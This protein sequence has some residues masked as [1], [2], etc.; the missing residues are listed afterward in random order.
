L[1]RRIIAFYTGRTRSASALLRRQ[2]EAIVADA[3]VRATLRRMVELAYILR[4]ELNNGAIDSFGEI[5]DENWAL[6]K[7][8]MSDITDDAIECWYAD[9]KAAG[10]LGGKILGAGAGGFLVFYAPEEAHEA[11]RH[12]LSDLKPM[13]F[14]FEPVGSRIIFYDPQT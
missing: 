9:A 11:I 12:K 3:K 6:K 4:S 8:L 14:G 13:Q 7:G 10:A 5:L 1:Q 2:S